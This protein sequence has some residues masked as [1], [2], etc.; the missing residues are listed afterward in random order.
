MKTDRRKFIQTLGAGAAGMGLTAT[1]P[2]FA[3]QTAKVTKAR[4]GGRKMVVQADDVGF[5]N[6]CNIGSFRTVEEGVVTAIDIMLDCPGT[7]DA[8]ERLREFPWISVGW[9]MHMWGAP[10]LDPKEVPSLIE[11]GGQFDE[12]FR[13]DLRNAEDVN[14]D[15]ALSELRA[16]LDR[17]IRILGKAPDTGGGGSDASPWNRAIK[18]VTDE[19]GLVYGFKSQPATPQAYVDHIVS[20]RE[21]GEEWA[22]YYSETKPRPATQADEKWASR[23]IVNVAGTTAYIDLLTDSVSEVEAKYDP[24]LFYTEDRAGILNYPDDVIAEQ[25]WHPGY[26]DYFVYRL[27]ER[28]NR[29]R[30]QQFVVGR[31]QDVAALCD[32]R[33]KNWIKENNIELINLRDALYGTNEYQNH[34][35]LIGSDLAIG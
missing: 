12:R 18:Q 30:A 35:R 22:Q 13:L 34:L 14:F 33:L 1:I 19:Y 32:V 28:G 7:V 25:S 23:K 27:G 17:C 15:E 6:V 8:L 4:V 29:A 24:V 26:V 31:V 9:H 11:K 2:S 16:Q 5:S 3:G 20:A 10:V 21:A